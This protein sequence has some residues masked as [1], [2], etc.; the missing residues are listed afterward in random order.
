MLEGLRVNIAALA[1]IFIVTV[2]TDVFSTN[3]GVWQTERGNI[4]TNVSPTDGGVLSLPRIDDVQLHNC[5]LYWSNI[6]APSA[7]ELVFDVETE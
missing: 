3:F 6:F 4:L 2:L 1:Q 5:L 7:V